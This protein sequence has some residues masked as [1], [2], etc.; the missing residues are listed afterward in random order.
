MYQLPAALLNALSDRT[1]GS[2]R[3]AARVARELSALPQPVT[4]SQFQGLARAIL[5]R[6]PHF[7]LV[8]HLLHS[9]GSNCFLPGRSGESDPAVQRQSS[10]WLSAWERARERIVLPSPPGSG[11]LRFLTWSHSGTVL[12]CVRRLVGEGAALEVLCAASHPGGE[13]A[14]LARELTALEVPCRLV[15]DA[16]ALKAVATSTWV[17]VGADAILPHEFWNKLGTGQLLS[18]AR[19]AGVPALVAAEGAKWS[20]PAWGMALHSPLPETQAESRFEA[21]DNQLVTHFCLDTGL[22]PPGRLTGSLGE[23]PLYSPIALAH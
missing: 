5:E 19:Q 3:L 2:S 13:G 9:V 6:R 21:V 20:H 8:F 14:V 15:D 16:A 12:S 10:L 18:A 17:V 23:P 11:S 4:E 7:A 1:L 22:V